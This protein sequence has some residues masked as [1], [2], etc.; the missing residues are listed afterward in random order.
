[1]TI[2]I[3]TFQN[4]YKQALVRDHGPIL[5]V[6]M[7]FN[8]RIIPG[9]VD[10]VIAP[11]VKEGANPI[12]LMKLARESIQATRDFDEQLAKI[13]RKHGDKYELGGMP[14]PICLDQYCPG[15]PSI[16]EQHIQGAKFLKYLMLKGFE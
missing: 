7:L 11:Y 4:L 15:S 1:M 3:D 2:D 12:P 16:P 6:K 14:C 8:P 5:M 13:A 10:T 9:P